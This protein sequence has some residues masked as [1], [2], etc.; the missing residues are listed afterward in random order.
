[1]TNFLIAAALGGAIALVMMGRKWGTATR[2]K[3]YEKRIK[4]LEAELQ[5]ANRN[6]QNARYPHLIDSHSKSMDNLTDTELAE[7]AFKSS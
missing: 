1:M 2:D 5:E 3:A 4:K 7:K 6:F